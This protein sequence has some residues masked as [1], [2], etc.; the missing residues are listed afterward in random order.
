MGRFYRKTDPGPQLADVAGVRAHLAMLESTIWRDPTLATARTQAGFNLTNV[1]IDA[2][3]L[4]GTIDADRLGV[5]AGTATAEKPAVLGASRNLDLLQLA[6]VRIGDADTTLTRGAA[7]VAAFNGTIAGKSLGTPQT[8]SSPGVIEVATTG[9]LIAR[10]TMA[11]AITGATMT[12]GTANGQVVWV[13]NE[14]GSGADLT[15]DTEAVSLVEGGSSIVIAGGS[16]RAFAW[17]VTSNRWLP[18]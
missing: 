13:R 8:I 9:L 2:G 17:D 3:D 4:T 16:G 1:D 14:G 18:L 15:F 10:I 11:S 6:T 12:A 5:T 7:G